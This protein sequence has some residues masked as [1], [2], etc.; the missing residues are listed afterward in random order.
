MYV[1][2]VNFNPK[3]IFFFYTFEVPTIWE[4]IFWYERLYHDIY[5]Q[6]V[7]YFVKPNNTTTV[8]WYKLVNIQTNE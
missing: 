1:H 3:Q 6:F 8:L 7:I 2:I 4:N 5:N